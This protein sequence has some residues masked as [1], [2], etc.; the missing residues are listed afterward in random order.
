MNQPF[1]GYF[2]TPCG[3]VWS[4]K[5]NRFLKPNIHSNGYEVIHFRAKG[6]KYLVHRLV[7]ETYLPNPNHYPII[8]HKDENKHNNCVSNLEWCTYAYNLTYNGLKIR[9]AHKTGTSVVRVEDNKEYYSI[10]AA[11]RDNGIQKTSII[12]ALKN[13]NFM[14]NGYH[15][16]R[17]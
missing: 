15:W 10:R 16:Q 6:K 12:R 5:S 14:A 17:S 8:N 3:R 2:V 7:A 1:E 13:K 4:Y 11:A 9:N